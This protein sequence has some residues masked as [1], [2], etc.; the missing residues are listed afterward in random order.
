M[1][2]LDAAAPALGPYLESKLKS[3]FQEQRSWDHGAERGR[4]T[5]IFKY[6]L[7]RERMKLL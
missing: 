7:Y 2:K 5:M 3:I 4:T 6:N 1:K